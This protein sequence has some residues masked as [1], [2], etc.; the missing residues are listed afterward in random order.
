MA[1]SKI[2]GKFHN[3]V[4]AAILETC[5]YIRGQRDLN[6]VALSGGVFQN[7]L[8]LRRTMAALR[9]R[10]FTVFTNTAVPANDGG[11]ALGQAAV[12]AERMNQRCA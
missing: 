2:S 4:A 3:T 12:A 8:L 7:E 11:L 5:R 6:V 1:A 9:S 10:H